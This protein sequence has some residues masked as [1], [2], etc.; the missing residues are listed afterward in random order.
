MALS[1]DFDILA[2]FILS[3]AWIF[4]YMDYRLVSTLYWNILVLLQV[5]MF[6]INSGSPS[7]LSRKSEQICWQTS[8][9]SGVKF[10]GTNFAQTFFMFNSSY[11]NF[12]T[13]SLSAFTISA[14]FRMLVRWCLLT[15]SL[16]MITVCRVENKDSQPV[17][18]RPSE[19]F[20]T[21]WK[22]VHE[23]ENCHHRPLSTTYSTQSE[24]FYLMKNFTLIFCSCF[25]SYI[26]IDTRKKHV[27]F[28]PLQK[29]N[30]S[31]KNVFLYCNSK[32]FQLFNTAFI[33]P[34][35][36]R[37]PPHAQSRYLIAKT[38]YLYFFEIFFHNMSFE[39][40]QISSN[41]PY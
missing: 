1:F 22:H 12:Q 25:L 8:F 29:K 15:V 19:N 14:I 10:F 41:S 23:I 39:F 27:Y 13:V 33:S 18:S 4:Q 11:K 24:F 7:N 2:F 28:L 38:S 17:P 37:M 26:I 30:W 35:S 31:T 9:W 5:M 20:Y 16:I 34:Y 3:P 36:P 6:F 21:I 40:S 32:H